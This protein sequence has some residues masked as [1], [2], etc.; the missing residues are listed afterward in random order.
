[1][2]ALTGARRKNLRPF[3]DSYIKFCTLSSAMEDRFEII[4]AGVSTPVLCLHLSGQEIFRVEYTNRQ[5]LMLTR[6][7]MASVVQWTSV[8]QGRHQEA[9]VIGG[10]IDEHL[11]KQR[12][13]LL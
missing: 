3:F 9:T 13:V 5:P 1:M 2:R 6:A 8:P 7:V 12:D 10:L 4:I 11:N